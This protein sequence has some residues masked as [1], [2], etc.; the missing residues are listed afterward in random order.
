MTDALIER[1]LTHADL[2][3]RSDGD[4][5]TVH[6]LAVPFDRETTVN[7]G[8]GAYQEVFRK[9]AFAQTI[10]GG[11]DR[12]KLLGN[13]NRAKF[14]LGKATAL[15]EDRAG[16]VGEFRVSNTREGDE[17]LELVRDGVLDAF[18]VGFA[19]VKDR[20]AGK[21]LVERLEVKLREVSLVAFPAYEGAMISGVRAQLADHLST[22]ELERLL[23]LAHDL[24]TRES[25]AAT[26]TSGDEPLP[27][28]DEP[29]FG[30]SP[31]IPTRAQ[32]LALALIQGVP[33]EPTD[34]DP[35]PAG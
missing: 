9:G 24:S 11:V 3:I 32:R 35:V 29:E 22:E 26:G 25:E 13:H 28:H 8:Y 23:A 21:G 5:R 31:R 33:S 2:E 1:A 17:A 10:N 19:P 12:V 6:G 7:D 27:T 16:L 14:P 34:R 15:R 4:G 30:H 20:K 18:S